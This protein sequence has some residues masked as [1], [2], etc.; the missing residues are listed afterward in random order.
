V[1]S[2]S[3]KSV[4]AAFGYKAAARGAEVPAMTNYYD[5]ATILE[6]NTVQN[7]E[8]IVNGNRMT[9]DGYFF[10]AEFV[11]TGDTNGALT[12]FT[13][14]NSTIN[15]SYV[16]TSGDTARP[17]AMY[18]FGSD[19]AEAAYNLEVNPV[20]GGFHVGI[21]EVDFGQVYSYSLA[22]S[23]TVVKCKSSSLSVGAS[24]KCTARVTGTDPTGTV[25]FSS[26][27]TGTFQSGSLSGDATAFICKVTKGVCS[28]KFQPTAPAAAVG[29]TASYSGDAVNGVSA[30]T[31]SLSVAQKTSKVGVSCVPKTGSVGSSSTCTV[32]VKGYLPTG[33]VLWSQSGTGSVTFS[34]NTCTLAKG[35]CSITLTGTTAGVVTIQAV[36]SGDPNNTSSSGTRNLSIK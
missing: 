31:F 18:E 33:T 23:S 26:N 16:L 3:G 25:T 8:M 11:F 17:I 9:P 2:Y 13:R 14:M 7:A 36:Y 30:G 20:K 21:G 1:V 19:T 4:H 35:S 6:T 24:V 27:V 34:S 12:T 22:A 32:K 10:D 15:L 29:V 28:V 5:N